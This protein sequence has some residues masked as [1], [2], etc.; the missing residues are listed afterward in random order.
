M[1]KA[2]WRAFAEWLKSLVSVSEEERRALERDR[3]PPC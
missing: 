3:P 2:F 1:W